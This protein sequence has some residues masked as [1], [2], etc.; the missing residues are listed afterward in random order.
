MIVK[1]VD[2]NGNETELGRVIVFGDLTC[3]GNLTPDSLNPLDNFMCGLKNL[4]DEDYVKVAMDVNHDER[5]DKY[6]Q[7]LLDKYITL[8]DDDYIINQ[9]IQ[10]TALSD[11]TIVNANTVRNEYMEKITNFETFKNSQYSIELQVDDDGYEWYA[12]KGA[13]A[14]TTVQD[15]L[16]VLPDDSNICIADSSAK[17]VTDTTKTVVSEEYHIG[18][19]GIYYKSDA[20]VDIAWVLF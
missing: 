5:I 16:N 2:A 20:V 10:A 15:I 9:N 6:D 11:L 18:I 3:E 12:L 13:T 1:K 4:N 14:T 19:K 17:E 8:N 7:E